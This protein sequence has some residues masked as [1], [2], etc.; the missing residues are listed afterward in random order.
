MED[1]NIDKTPNSS[2]SARV[3][4]ILRC[5]IAPRSKEDEA[6]DMSRGKYR[7]STANTS[8]SSGQGVMNTLSD[9]K[10]SKAPPKEKKNR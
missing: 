7:H 5:D 8:W 1:A 4:D 3:A 9:H 6:Q 2:R 10:K